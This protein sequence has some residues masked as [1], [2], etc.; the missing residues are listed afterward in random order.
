MRILTAI[1]LL[2]AP[3]A[4]D[5]WKAGL[6]EVKITPEEPI[7]LAGYASRTKPF[8]KVAADLYA[9]ALALEDAAG[10]RA[11]L[12]TSDLIGFRAAVAEPICERLRE[13][14]G[15]KRE[16]ILLSVSH[17]H[18]G[19][20]LSLDAQARPPY[21]EEDARKTVE[22]T[23]RLQDKVVALVEQALG[24]LEPARLA[25]S[26]GVAHFVMNRR[27]FTPNG[28]ILG[29]NP[30][31]PVDR[32]VPVLRVATPEGKLR[33][34]V[35]GY[36]C[37]NTTLGGN[38]YEVSGDYA[39]FA[40]AHVQEKLPGVQAMFVTG[41]AG[42]SNPHPRG[43]MDL[44][45]DHGATLGKEVLRVLG[46]KLQPV[47]G[48]I[49]VALERAPLP[50]EDVPAADELEKLAPKSPSYR[51]GVIDQQL[52]AYRRGD[53]PATHYVAPIALWQFGDDLTLLGLSG[54]VVVDYVQVVEQAIG[55][56]R[57][58][59]AAYCNDVFGYLPSAR[60]S[61]EGGYETRGVYYG[62]AGFFAPTAQE[63]VGRTV[64]SLA[65]KT[66]RKLP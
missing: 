44:A 5:D 37:H 27:E 13:K 26:T 42:D 39:G 15:L 1:V 20:S 23:R 55:P 36:A 28:V 33:A 38:I 14:V 3:Q 58:W 40:Q 63:V 9:K 51:K 59:V 18:T 30:R 48:P 22:Y 62:S 6:A 4:G 47:R 66:G 43:T 65:E 7:H 29:V 8:E 56:L 45:R 49:R 64:R 31:G 50:L 25:W 19:P 46:A 41:C 10:N 61:R 54:E 12:V 16:Q 57:L 32:S 52:A 21:S 60:V 53:K 2:L 35:F 34:V 17:T 24:K 11:V